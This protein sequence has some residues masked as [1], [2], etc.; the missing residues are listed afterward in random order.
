MQGKQNACVSIGKFLLYNEGKS[1]LGSLHSRQS[2][3]K[4]SCCRH[5]NS[6]Q[7]KVQCTLA[8]LYFVHERATRIAIWNLFLLTGIA[9][10][11]LISG[12]VIEDLGWQW[13]FWLCAIIF[14]LCVLGVIFM[15]PETT[16][17]RGHLAQQS[18]VQNRK[19]EVEHI[20]TKGQDIEH[21]A[22][23]SSQGP[24]CLVS[25]ILIAHR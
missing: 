20:E 24:P 14:G 2:G 6:R 19:V 18:K 12:Y 21:I 16:Y 4:L 22:P 15:V 8:D 13:T 23:I 9:G 25:Y 10:G 11:S 1:F 7:K 3:S 17:R 5:G